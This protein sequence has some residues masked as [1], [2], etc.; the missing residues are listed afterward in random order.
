MVKQRATSM[1]H[2]MHVLHLEFRV[3]GLGFRV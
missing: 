3:G 2:D 1:V